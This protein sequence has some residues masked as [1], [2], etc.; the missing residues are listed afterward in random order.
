MNTI[1]AR[2]VPSKRSRLSPVEVAAGQPVLSD[3][4]DIARTGDRIA[5]KGLGNAV[6]RI[7]LTGG[8]AIFQLAQGNVDLGQFEPGE[9]QVVF[10]LER[11]EILELQGQ[12][13]TIPACV[14][15]KRLSAIT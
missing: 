6:G 8:R 14:L 4:P 2:A 15:G 5:G 7:G 12:Q 10:D 11:R 1:C 13:V 3:V 9:R